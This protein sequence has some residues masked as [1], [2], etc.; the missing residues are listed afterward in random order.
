MDLDWTHIKA[1]DILAVL[2]SFAPAAGAPGG[3]RGG[4]QR[5]TVYPSDYGLERMEAERVAGPQVRR[6][7]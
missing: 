1:V 6:W 7:V 4:V 2:R 5:V 3:V